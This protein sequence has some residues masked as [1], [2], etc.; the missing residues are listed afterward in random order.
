MDNS[1]GAAMMGKKSNKDGRIKH[2]DVDGQHD[3]VYAKVKKLASTIKNMG[4]EREVFHRLF[5]LSKY[6]RMHFMEEEKL[7]FISGYRQHQEHKQQHAE[8]IR[9]I[10]EIKSA[11]HDDRASQTL[12][13]IVQD[14]L[15][16][17]LRQHIETDDEAFKVWINSG[18]RQTRSIMIES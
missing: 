10:G 6:A 3:E 16:K 11:Y 7:M 9:K 1:K 8:F 5:S 14:T 4:S 17:W 2:L 15:G 13:K 18:N 12:P